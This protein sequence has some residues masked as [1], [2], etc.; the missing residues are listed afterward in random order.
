MSPT[1]HAITKADL[2]GNEEELQKIFESITTEQLNEHVDIDPGN[3]LLQRIIHTFDS[4][5]RYQYLVIGLFD[6]PNVDT[7]R[8]DINHQHAQ[9]GLTP[10]M[11]AAYRGNFEVL[12]KLMSL[13]ADMQLVGTFNRT[14]FRYAC[15]KGNMNAIELLLPFVE[16]REYTLRGRERETI[17]EQVQKSLEVTH[18][19]PLLDLM[20]LLA[21]SHEKRLEEVWSTNGRRIPTKSS[22]QLNFS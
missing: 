2:E 10:L 13:G 1:F 3:I 17:I 15:R 21:I 8:L 5:R 11:V 4:G 20:K 9:N 7:S 19:Y 14:A 18:R 22:K 16:L 12:E 6:S